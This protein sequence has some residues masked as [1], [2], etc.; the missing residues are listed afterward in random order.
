MTDQVQSAPA[1][2]SPLLAEILPR[3]YRIAFAL[4]VF[5]AFLTQA[6][7]IPTIDNNLGPFEVVGMAL[8]GAFLLS[9]RTRRP[10]ILNPANRAMLAIL[11]VAAISL[12]NIDADRLGAG[13]I[14]L[15]IQLFLVLF[16]VTLFNVQSQYRV[17]PE[18][19]LGLTALALLVVGPWIIVAGLNAQDLVQDVG[20]FRNRAHMASYMLTAFWI[21]LMYSQ[22]PRT[23]WF[24]RVAAYGGVAMTLYAVA[25]A[26]RRSVY[27]SLVIGL[28]ALG[29]AVL[30]SSHGR[31]VRL[32]VAGLFVV[33]L[34]YVMY[35][36]GPR[37][38]PQLGFFQ[39]RVGMIDDRL[40]SALAVSEEEAAEKSFFALQR[41]GVR[42]AF[43]AHPLLGI[44]WGGFAKSQYSPTGHEV[45]STPL[46]FLAETGLVGLTLYALFMMAVLRSVWISYLAM[47]NTAYNNSY[48][49]LAVGFSSLTVSYAYNRHITERTFWLLMA[50]IFAAELFAARVRAAQQLLAEESPPVETSSLAP[51]AVDDPRHRL[52]TSHPWPSPSRSA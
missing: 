30:A 27:L 22:W 32:I 21:V 20:P 33:G 13:L 2:R 41:E 40:G 25:V 9:P 1:P 10:L 19:I 43:T 26:G 37:Y 7:F 8:I 36:Y 47:R 48:M 6:K 29:A 52:P 17:S 35:N 11:L 5:A 14:N 16:L 50:V 3:S 28:A 31:R 46:R 49:V 15:A 34:I 44:G 39:D 23:G 38:L 51:G 24:H 42:H 45:H 4:V 18:R 12:L